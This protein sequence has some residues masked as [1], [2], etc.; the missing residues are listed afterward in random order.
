MRRL[1][2]RY[3]VDLALVG[4]ACVWGLTFVTVKD[5]VETYPPFSFMAARFAIAALVLGAIFPR[6]VG[7]LD[8]KVWGAGALAGLVLTVG[9]VG[10]TLG[11]MSIEA[12]RAG[13]ITGTFV[14][15]TPI[16]QFLLLRRRVGRFAI[17]GVVL[18]T[19][20]LWLLTSVDGGGWGLGDSL[21]LLAATGF[22]FHMIVLGAVSARYPVEQLTFVQMVVATVLCSGAAL[23][24]ERP[25]ALPSTGN[26]WFALVLTGVLASAA[27][28]WVQTYAQRHISPTRTALILI[29]EPVFAGL[30]G[31]V[32]LGERLGVPGWAGSALIFGGMLVSEVAGNLHRA[33]EKLP[34]ET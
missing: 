6:A 4:V 32:L 30:F 23:V 31:F 33:R 28:F 34:L 9:Y 15:I 16:L 29:T 25:L 14:V 26:V 24:L 1:V 7:R 11:L 22:S 12:S 2:A 5:A 13:F 10:Q 8:R 20:G 3:H 18:A 19:V 27:A 21:T 17:T